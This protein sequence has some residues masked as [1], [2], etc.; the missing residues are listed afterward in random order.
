MKR[1]KL[2]IKI[3]LF[4]IFFGYVFPELIPIAIPIATDLFLLNP[5]IGFA[6]F[7]CALVVLPI[8]AV[9]FVR[10]NQKSLI[11]KPPPLHALPHQPRRYW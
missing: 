11:Y 10:K 6:F 2:F 9:S 5:L 1:K 4:F 3:F 8:L 7:A